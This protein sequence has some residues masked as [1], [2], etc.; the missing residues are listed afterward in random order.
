LA[1]LATSGFS[2]RNLL[3]GVSFIRAIVTNGYMNLKQD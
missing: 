3:H 1:S 2:V